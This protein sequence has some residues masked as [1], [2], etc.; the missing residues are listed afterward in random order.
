MPTQKGKTTTKTKKRPPRAVNKIKGKELNVQEAKIDRWFNDGDFKLI[1]NNTMAFNNQP[2][3]LLVLLNNVWENIKRANPSTKT[4]AP[5]IMLLFSSI[6]EV[7]HLHKDRETYQKQKQEK[8]D[9][10]IETNEYKIDIQEGAISTQKRKLKLIKDEVKNSGR[11]FDDLTHKERLTINE[12][13]LNIK[14]RE[15]IIIDLKQQSKNYKRSKELIMFDVS[16][17]GKL[18]FDMTSQL[19]SK[20]EKL[21]MLMK[22][23]NINPK[24][25]EYSTGGIVENGAKSMFS[26]LGKVT[27]GKP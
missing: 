6:A 3:E 21:I 27:N 16:Q 10:W 25:V 12:I 14:D 20:N 8:Y 2:D 18:T 13:K 26:G 19:T 11:K 5:S 23:F 17:G 4:Y 1:T 22:E 7:W 15:I 9:E 24:I